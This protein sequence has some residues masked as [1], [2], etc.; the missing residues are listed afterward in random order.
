MLGGA[1]EFVNYILYSL[2]SRFFLSMKA[3]LLLLFVFAFGMAQAQ[4]LP[5][6][7]RLM[8][9]Q[10][11]A[12]GLLL[13]RGWVFQPGD[14]PNWARPELDDSNWQPINLA[15]SLKQLPQVQQTHYGWLRLRFRAGESLRQRALVLSIFQYTASEIY[16]NGRLLRR[17]GSLGNPA[18]QA[19]PQPYWPNGEPIELP[20]A[21]GPEQVLAVRFAHWQ[22]LTSLS[23]FFVPFFLRARLDGLPQAVLSIRRE[24]G[25]KTSDMLLVSLFLLL[26]MLHLAFYRYNPAQR[27][28]L[29]FT[30]YTLG[31][32]LS[33]LCTG[34]M[35]DIHRVAVRIGADWA[36]YVF[37]QTAN[38]F[39]IRAL[40]CLFNR[41]VGKIYYSLWGLNVVS[42]LLLT[43][44]QGLGWYPTVVFMV[45]VTAEQ[46]W[47]TMTALRQRKQS[48]GIIASG[49][50][51]ALSLLLAFG[52]IARYHPELLGTR[53]LTIPLHT[54]LV[55]PAFLSP[56]LAISLF[57][58]RRFSLDSRL[59][60][61]KLSQ[62]QH[63]SARMLAQEQEKQAMLAAQNETLEHQVTQRTAELQQSLE[64]LRATQTQLVQQ[65]KMASLGE[66]AAGIAHEM[67]NPINFVNNFSEVSVDLVE[68]LKEGPLQ[69][70]PSSEKEYA[71][72]I[73]DNLTQNLQKVS[74]HGQRAGSIVRGMLQHSRASTAEPR[75]PTDLNALV[76]EYLRL[77]YEEVQTRDKSFTAV[78]TT[79][80]DPGVG[81]VNLVPQDIGRVLL[82]LFTNAFYAV[83]QRQQQSA[84]GGY[85]PEVVVS[86]QR[87]HRTAVI[88]IRDNGT[89]M[90][91]AV[92]QKVFQPFFTTKPA[93]EGTGLGL[94]LSHDIITKG[95]SGTL[96]VKAQEGEYTEFEICLPL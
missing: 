77:S 26:T 56:A 41:R 66:L 54:L 42:M 4:A 10:L 7:E 38:L 21:P 71:D 69:H 28:N 95:H 89:G 18:G 34:F 60:Q 72:E 74:A 45:L 88:L 58:A 5:Q 39:A 13:D 80:F 79:H 27:A 53:I 62:V 25:Y 36:S 46:L 76:D 85:Q 19:A 70:L 64:H 20:L 37:V 24:A 92:R 33:F 35:D 91:E 31:V 57:L 59:L 63:L 84:A 11:P 50:A 81:T 68:E 48:A 23:S 82:N 49:Y 52:F 61:V 65:E 12:S 29:Y 90:P 83:R 6:Q 47:L 78:L 2:P 16:F 22:P 17:Y 40:Y 3:L 43:F 93:G 32:A 55:F 67:Q 8:L 75:S 14:D 73:L 1:L 96:S 44:S 15:L 87:R 51:V 9:E 30:L 86:T 94:S